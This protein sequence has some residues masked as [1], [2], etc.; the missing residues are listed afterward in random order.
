[1]IKLFHDQE[2]KSEDYT[3]LGEIK[4]IKTMSKK[5]YSLGNLLHREYE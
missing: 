1:M 5:Q 3:A 2:Q 4:P